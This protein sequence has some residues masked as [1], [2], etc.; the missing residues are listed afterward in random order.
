MSILPRLLD[1][2]PAFHSVMTHG[3]LSAAARAL[4]LAQPTVRRH[5]EALEEGL[6]TQLFTRAANGL[7]PTAMAHTLLPMAAA[8][9]EE[10]RAL[11]RVA[12]A[13]RDLLKGPVRITCSRIVATHVLPPLM[14]SLRSTAPDITY[15]IAA[16]DVAENLARRAADIAIRFTAPTQLSL[17]ALKLPDV[18]L[19]LFASPTLADI[20]QDLNTLP[21]L[22]DDRADQIVPAL[23]ALGAPVPENV[24][25]RCDDPLALLANL[26]AGVG[27][28]ICQV[29]LAQRLGLKRLHPQITHA[30]PAWLVV[31][32][33]QAQIA[34]IRHVFDHLK[35][36]LPAVM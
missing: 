22:S 31:H 19:G 1:H 15:E 30:M 25:L 35:T 29:K 18:A 20:K 10:A 8:V 3:S 12:S 5:I 14:A 21:F 17:K 34:R 6:D 28:G 33:D 27:A 7:T 23:T 24:V 4:H 32:E 13:E 36:H 9:L 16:T 11:A 26:Q 2:I